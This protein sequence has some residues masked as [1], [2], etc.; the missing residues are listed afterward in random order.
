MVYMKNTQRFR[1]N[2]GWYDTFFSA[3]SDCPAHCSISV[4][5]SRACRPS[6]YTLRVKREAC[7]SHRFTRF[8]SSSISS[9]YCRLL[10]LLLSNKKIQSLSEQICIYFSVVY[11]N[12]FELLF[13][14]PGSHS[15]SLTLEALNYSIKIF[16]HLK[17]CLATQLKRLKSL[18][19]QSYLLRQPFV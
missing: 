5:T 7:S 18:T 10:F 4:C 2:P 1:V 9:A 12:R 11:L 6:W 8:L 14:M 13:H 16:N 15:K 19:H 3:M 17:L